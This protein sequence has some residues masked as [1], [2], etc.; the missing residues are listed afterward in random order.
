MSEKEAKKSEEAKKD[1]KA[2]VKTDV[3]APVESVKSAPVHDDRPERLRQCWNC[4]KKLNDDG[5]CEKCGF[6]VNQVHNVWLE[7]D[8]RQYLG[9]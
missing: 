1:T 4:G 6:D 8:K 5:V 7:T 3:V 2:E 9:Q